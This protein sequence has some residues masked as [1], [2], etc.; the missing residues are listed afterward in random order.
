MVSEQAKGLNFAVADNNSNPYC[1]LQTLNFSTEMSKEMLSFLM[2]Q[3]EVQR[4]L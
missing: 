2:P 1:L 3:Q 4:S